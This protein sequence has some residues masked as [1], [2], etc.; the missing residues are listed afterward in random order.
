[1]T[2]EAQRVRSPADFLR[3]AVAAVV[4]V[5]LLLV[6]LLLVVLLLVEWLFGITLVVFASDLTG[7]AGSP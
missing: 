1:M 4:L 5:V 2:A 3:L 7:R 6:V